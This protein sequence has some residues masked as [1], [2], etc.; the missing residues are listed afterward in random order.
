MSSL[1]LEWTWF[2]EWS[3]NGYLG[4]DLEQIFDVRKEVGSLGKRWARWR[5]FLIIQS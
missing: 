4:G 1:V 2:V 3:R 5:S